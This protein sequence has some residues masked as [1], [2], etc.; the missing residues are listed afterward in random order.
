MIRFVAGLLFSSACLAAATPPNIILIYS[1]ELQHSDLGAFGGSIPTPALDSLALQ[2]MRFTRAYACASMCTP[3]RF[4]VLT[5]AFPGRCKSE[6]YLQHY[7]LDEPYSVAWNTNIDAH[8]L[9]IPRL[10]SQHGYTTGMVGK[11]HLGDEGFS[12]LNLPHLESSANLNDPAVDRKLKQRHDILAA[13]V[14]RTA[15]FDHAASVMYMNF[16]NHP[17]EA[18]HK[19]NFP[20]ITSGALDFLDQYGDVPFF[21][22]VAPTA[23]HGPNHRDDLSRNIRYTPEGI[24]DDLEQYNIDQQAL[25]KVVRDMPNARAMRY[26]GMVQMD[27]LVGQILRKVEALGIADNTLIFFM[28]DHNIE[29]G[30][31]TTYEKGTH[32]PFL[33]R[34]PGVIAPNTT[35]RNLI[36][37]LDLLPTIAD[38]AGIGVPG[39]AVIDGVNLRPTLEAPETPV[40][41]YIFSEAGYTRSISDG[42]F[43]YIAL[44]YPERLTVAMESGQM[45]FAVNYIDRHNQGQSQIAINSYPHYFDIDQLYDLVAD[46][47]EQNNLAR[48]PAYTQVMAELQ[49]ELKKHLD[50]FEHPFDLTPDP[51]YETARY[52]ELTERTRQATDVESI[53]WYRRDHGRVIWPP[54][55]AVD[56]TSN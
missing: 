24:R 34:W 2:G 1:D 11:W 38:A 31:A 28:A 4:G 35:N 42:N 54:V 7:P 53:F 9:T 48:N 18:L 26:A 45:D 14:R 13:E 19:H 47:Y 5:G 6:S 32:V 37:N 39:S 52:R 10:L 16:D 44:R 41:K 43:K 27:H 25:Y 23:V 46:P 56:S 17:V 49:A 20:W 29:P 55:D 36:S 33:A 50:T 40:R 22:Y 21:L 51:F 8:Q 3:S 15:G 30:K 12:G